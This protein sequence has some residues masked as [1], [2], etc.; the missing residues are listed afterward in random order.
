MK[1]VKMIGGALLC[2]FVVYQVKQRTTGILD[3]E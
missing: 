3:D 2:A 1:L